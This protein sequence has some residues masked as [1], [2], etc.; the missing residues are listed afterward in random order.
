LDYPSAFFTLDADNQL[1]VERSWNAPLCKYLSSADDK[2]RRK[3]FKRALEVLFDMMYVQ[4]F[5]I[6]ENARTNRVVGSETSAFRD[7]LEYVNAV[8]ANPDTE[9]MLRPETLETMQ[10]MAS[11]TLWYQAQNE[12]YKEAGELYVDD[13][14]TRTWRYS[15]RSDHALKRLPE[16]VQTMDIKPIITAVRNKFLE[17]CG[18]MHK[19]E[20]VAL[21]M[22]PTEKPK[23]ELHHDRKA[24]HMR[25]DDLLCMYKQV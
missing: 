21:P 11:A 19:N 14:K 22:F 18:F 8:L 16:L 7:V 4:E 17:G 1:I 3:D 24:L 25:E 20:K 10:E 15:E 12:A 2:Q 6:R 5:A 13:Y 23:G 9:D